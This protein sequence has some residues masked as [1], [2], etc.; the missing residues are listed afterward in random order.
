MNKIG[1]KFIINLACTGVIPTKA[2]N[3]SV[4]ITTDEIVS[5]VNR[6]IE[7]G[8]QMVH[9]HAR[10]DFGVQTSNPQRYGEIISAIRALPGGRE[11]IV[12]V[13]T[14]GRLDSSF[15]TRAQVLDLAGDMKPDMASLTLSSL[16]FAQ[17][18]SINEP[19]TIRQLAERMLD[20][21]IKPELEVFD[22][23]MANFIHV[24]AKE[25]LIEPPYYVNILLGNITGAQ[26]NLLQL[27]AI[28]S[29]LPAETIVGIAGL[30]RFQLESNGLA[31]LVADA[32]R[33]GLEDNIWF[34]NQR[35]HLA[36]NSMLTE[37]VIAQAAQFYRTLMTR[38][39]AR[40][41]IGLPSIS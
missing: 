13:T 40:A 24:L 18:A 35:E 8:V 4:P 14:S 19:Q 17:S 15:E 37:R 6:A 16:N 2:M 21:G 25:K 39:E 36:T 28:L 1:E 38:G 30:G 32:A 12:G 26:P 34:D 22:I 3:E 10:D 11:L 41:R 33:V 23:G 31:I 7:L 9:I 20:Q 27:A 5:D 29:A